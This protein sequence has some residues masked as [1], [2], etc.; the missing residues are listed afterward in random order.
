M[1][2][3][4]RVKHGR[5]EG[6]ELRD[7]KRDGISIG[8]KDTDN[9]FLRNVITGNARI[10][11]LFREEAEPLGAHRNRF[12]KNV[13]MDNGSEGAARSPVVIH[14]IHH[15][16]VFKDNRIGFTKSSKKPLP[17]IQTNS[18][19]KRLDATQNEF[20]NVIQAVLVK[21]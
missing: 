15:D 4:W 18:K 2:V 19:S 5:F 16:L 21:D 6:N 8:H 7:N 20:E 3:C 17:A 13:I 1:F 10:G 12:E 11:L 14:G 9:V